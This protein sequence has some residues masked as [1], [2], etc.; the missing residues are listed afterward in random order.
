MD[1]RGT[2]G[3]YVYGA[4]SNVMELSIFGPVNRLLK[5]QSVICRYHQMVGLSGEQS[6]MSKHLSI[7]SQL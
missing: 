1:I 6:K 2:T 3:F 5:L 4:Y 7:L